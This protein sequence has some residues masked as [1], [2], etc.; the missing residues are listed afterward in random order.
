MLVP[1]DYEHM[2]CAILLAFVLHHNFIAKTC[3]PLAVA[4]KSGYSVTLRMQNNTF[5]TLPDT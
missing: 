2:E 3:L 4:V 5:T 1:N